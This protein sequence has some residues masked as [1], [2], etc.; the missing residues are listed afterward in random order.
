MI[1]PE[2]PLQLDSRNTTL[3]ESD[4]SIPVDFPTVPQPLPYQEANVAMPVDS[5]TTTQPLSLED[6]HADIQRSMDKFN[7]LEGWMRDHSLTLHSNFS[8]HRLLDFIMD[9]TQAL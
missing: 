9:T 3:V 5:L 7:S 6:I 1:S 2:V 8:Q 4:G